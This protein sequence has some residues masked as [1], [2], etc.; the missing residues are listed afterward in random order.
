MADSCIA[1][2]GEVCHVV[3]V[4]GEDEGVVS[5]GD[6]DEVSVDDV[7]RVRSSSSA[8]TDRA[9]SSN[10]TTRQGLCLDGHAACRSRS[11]SASSTSRSA[12]DAAS[13]SSR[14][15][16]HRATPSGRDRLD[17]CSCSQQ[18]HRSGPL[19]GLGLLTSPGVLVEQRVD[20]EVAGVERAGPEADLVDEI[21]SAPSPRSR[22]HARRAG[23]RSRSTGSLVSRRTPGSRR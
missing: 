20:D 14:L 7:R 1:L 2:A 19:V 23:A 4:G 15:V 3:A 18:R 8:P 16:T 9:P 5:F 21:G 17:R 10:P 22:G 12:S 11:T 6:D 13:G